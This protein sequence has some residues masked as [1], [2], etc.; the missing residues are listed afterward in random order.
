MPETVFMTDAPIAPGGQ[1]FSMPC[2]TPVTGTPFAR[3]VLGDRAFQVCDRTDAEGALAFRPETGGPWVCVAHTLV[4]GW[5][6]IGA[7]IVQSDPET[8]MHF[9]TTHAVRQ[10]G[11]FR[12]G[13]EIVFDTLGMPWSVR[14]IDAAQAEVV[15]G[16]EAPRRVDP[17]V[18]RSD[19]LRERAIE[20]LIAAYP[21]LAERFGP[22][23]DHWAVRLAHGAVVTPIL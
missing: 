5:L 23:I 18:A 22:E 2:A 21:D 4:D 15:L 16:D 6:R 12:E 13:D 19:D 3:I 17:S 7:D 20:V 9:L 8:L 1:V 11:W 10:S 14:L